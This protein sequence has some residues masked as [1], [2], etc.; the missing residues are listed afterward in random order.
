MSETIILNVL[1]VL[2]YDCANSN[3]EYEYVLWCGSNQK[4]K[5]KEST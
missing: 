2:G 5:T 1:A 3:N 4:K